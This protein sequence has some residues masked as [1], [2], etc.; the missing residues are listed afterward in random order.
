MTYYI[1]VILS[2]FNI[3]DSIIY[4]AIPKSE[5]L[6]KTIMVKSE[7]Y[8]VFESEE[9][10]LSAY[11]KLSESEKEYARIFVGKEFVVLPKPNILEKYKL[12]P[13]IEKAT[14]KY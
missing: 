11:N 3:G 9:D 1:L 5:Y 10:I 12:L 6:S 8:G 13:K 7:I 4:N 14:K 2:V